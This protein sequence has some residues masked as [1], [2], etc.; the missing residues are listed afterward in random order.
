MPWLGLTI[1][2]I[3]GA[4]AGALTDYGINDEF[5]KE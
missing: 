5:I 1:G 3:V 2:A 4:I